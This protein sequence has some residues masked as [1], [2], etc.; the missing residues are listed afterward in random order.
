MKINWKIRLK[1]KA[2][3]LAAIPAILLL[4]QQVCGLFGVN[5]ATE[6]LAEQ[7]ISIVGTAFA[8]LSIL[9]IVNDPTTAGLLKDSSQALTYTEPKADA[10]PET[11]T[12]TVN[13]EE[14]EV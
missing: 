12:E 1:N 13:A 6:G 4:A 5:L 8:L 9:G 3:W 11:K 14:A 7:L 10:A 2:F